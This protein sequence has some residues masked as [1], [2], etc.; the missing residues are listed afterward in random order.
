MVRAARKKN[1]GGQRSVKVGLITL[2]P[3]TAQEEKENYA[4]KSRGFHIGRSH[5]ISGK[6]GLGG[7]ERRRLR[8][9][10]VSGRGKGE[11]KRACSLGKKS[12][13]TWDG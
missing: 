2:P 13:A 6:G 10:D 8:G 11:E 4:R 12:L 1:F 9:N 3:L 5:N 7:G